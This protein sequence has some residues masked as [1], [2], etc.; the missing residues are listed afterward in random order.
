ML[1]EE[2]AQR[3]IGAVWR[4]ARLLTR[5][6]VRLLVWAAAACAPLMYVASVMAGVRMSQPAILI[7]HTTLKTN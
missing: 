6:V 3:R 1:S 2:D 4:F 7:L 5:C